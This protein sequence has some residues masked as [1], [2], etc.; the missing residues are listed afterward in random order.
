MRWKSG[1]GLA[2]VVLLGSGCSAAS[3]AARPTSASTVSRRSQSGLIPA[4]PALHD[5]IDLSTKRVQAGGPLAAT[6]V[7]VN[8]SSKSINLSSPC[9]PQ[10]GVILTNK[11]MPPSAIG[12]PHPGRCSTRPLLVHPGTSVR[13]LGTVPTTYL[14][15]TASPG[16]EVVQCLPDREIPPLPAGTYHAVLTGDGLALP[17]P[18]PVAVDVTAGH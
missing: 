6:L 10:M 7:I 8:D 2:A 9:S 18:T 4:N 17:P 5:H 14:D 16:L 13:T 1:I 15:C 12:T 11:S 3:Q